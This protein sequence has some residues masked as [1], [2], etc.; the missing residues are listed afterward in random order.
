MRVG[1]VDCI[2]AGW[3]CQDLSV[4]GKR[5]GLA[6][7]RSGLF[8][9]VIRLAKALR[10]RWLFLENVPGLLSS[11][12]GRDFA[13]VLNSLDNIGFD[14]EWRVLGAKWFGVPQDRR[15]VYIVGH[16]R[17]HPRPRSVLLEP[18]SGTGDPAPVREATARTPRPS[19]AGPG[20][21]GCEGHE[22]A[23]ALKAEGGGPCPERVRECVVAMTVRSNGFAGENENLIA[24][25]LTRSAYADGAS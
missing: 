8:H 18:E 25:P 19:E 6:G 5:A 23:G 24:S 13:E 1:Y 15:R 10:P 20:S 16:S 22:T 7:E 2:T 11:N 14:A 4:A 17:N 12:S 9:E 21:G 3:P